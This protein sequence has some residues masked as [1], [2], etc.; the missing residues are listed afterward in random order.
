MQYDKHKHG[1]VPL[2]GKLAG[3]TTRRVVNVIMAHDQGII[4]DEQYRE[5]LQDLQKEF[6]ENER[7]Q[8]D[9]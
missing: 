6:S 1:R 2:F 3:D 7:H 4:S 9:C 5:T 8:R